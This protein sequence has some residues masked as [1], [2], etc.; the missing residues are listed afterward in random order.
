MRRRR[1][2]FGEVLYPVRKLIRLPAELAEQIH[3]YRLKNGIE[4][5]NEAMR[6]L[7][8]LGLEKAKA[9]R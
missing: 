1:L 9:L 5:E 7:I 8:A 4:S 3:A 6:R 2:Q